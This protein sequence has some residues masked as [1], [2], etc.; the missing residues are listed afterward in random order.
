M[1]A[2]GAA[3]RDAGARVYY[4]HAF[5]GAITASSYRFG[6]PVVSATANELAA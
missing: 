3:G 6:D 4:E 1:V 2:A 5:M